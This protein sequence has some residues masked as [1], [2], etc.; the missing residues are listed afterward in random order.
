MAHGQHAILQ[1]DRDHHAIMSIKPPP[2]TDDGLRQPVDS[3]NQTAAVWELVRHHTVHNPAPARAARAAERFAPRLANGREAAGIGGAT[4]D[5]ALVALTHR[6]VT[7][8]LPGV[9]TGATPP[10]WANSMSDV[11]ATLPEVTA[12]RPRR[13]RPRRRRTDE[14]PGDVRP[15]QRTVGGAAGQPAWGDFGQPVVGIV[16]G[17]VRFVIVLP[18][19]APP[20]PQMWYYFGVCAII[21]KIVI[22]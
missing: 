13:R 17:V 7:V 3:T 18:R 14:R 2:A 12:T 16:G 5:R 1:P 6:G 10:C 22:V 19:G 15:D 4:L 9:A 21:P 11:N 8:P 20:P